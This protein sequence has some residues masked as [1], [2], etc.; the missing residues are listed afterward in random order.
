MIKCK[1][2]LEQDQ[3]EQVSQD[4]VVRFCKSSLMEATQSLWATEQT[5]N[6]QRPDVSTDNFDT[7]HLY[8]KLLKYNLNK[9]TWYS[10]T[11]SGSDETGHKFVWT[12]NDPCLTHLHNSEKKTVKKIAGCYMGLTHCNPMGTLPVQ[13]RSI[14]SSS[15]CCANLVERGPRVSEPVTTINPEKGWRFF[16]L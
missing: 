8:G 5:G 14:H 16:I 15:Q 7:F 3:L 4:H 1:P 2:L 13:D 9:C 11:D 6:D 10:L 12:K